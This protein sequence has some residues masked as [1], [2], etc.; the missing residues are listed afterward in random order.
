LICLLG[1]TTVEPT[2][3][4]WPGTGIPFIIYCRR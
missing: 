4:L 2:V 1:G 3:T